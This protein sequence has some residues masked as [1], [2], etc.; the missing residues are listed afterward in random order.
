MKLQY[1][2]V[3]VLIFIFSLH[4]MENSTQSI[5]DITSY[6]ELGT[7]EDFLALSFITKN[8]ELPDIA[9]VIQQKKQGQPDKNFFGFLNSTGQIGSATA[10][11][12]QISAVNITP[13]G[14]L[15]FGSREGKTGFYIT[16]N[17]QFKIFSKFCSSKVIALNSCAMIKAGAVSAGIQQEENSK[18]RCKVIA[19]VHANGNLFCIHND[20]NYSIL[21][22][23]QGLQ[24]N[25]VDKEIVIADMVQLSTHTS[26]PPLVA[27]AL[28][29]INSNT[30]KYSKSALVY[31]PLFNKNIVFEHAA[32]VCD[33]RFLPEWKI[34]TASQDN[35][36]TIFDVSKEEKLYTIDYQKIIFGYLNSI[37]SE[38]NNKNAN[39]KTICSTPSTCG[40]Y[41]VTLDDFCN[42]CIWDVADKGKLLN[43]KK[44][45]DA[46][47]AQDS[48]LTISPDNRYICV[49]NK[50][51]QKIYNFDLVNNV[52][53]S[54]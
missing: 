21:H 28:H 34:C 48:K 14:N 22:L 43:K 19:S 18:K 44:L 9:Y 46:N 41:I 31:N 17:D 53:L 24:E 16:Q 5:Q 25:A 49:Y 47:F 12:G 40:K 10:I 20:D 36:L 54:Q 35:M 23:F 39:Q 15:L 50:N 11:H 8:N 13:K 32:K 4:A 42:L 6:F 29:Y 3:F 45:N 26:L 38:N 52:T 37:K 7:E 51:N 33:I 2:S 30:G 1:L 27:Y